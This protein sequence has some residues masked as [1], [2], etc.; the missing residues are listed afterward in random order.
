MSHIALDLDDVILDFTGGV[1]LA[2]K[3]EYGVEVVFNDWDMSKVLNP[4]IGYNWWTWMREREWLW[5]NF[6]AV[7]GAIG[8]IESLRR[9]GHYLEIVTS[10]PDWAEHNVWKW[11]GKWRPRVNKVT[12][13][14]P[15][16]D[17]IRF[18]N[19]S[20]IV[21]DKPETVNQWQDR[22]RRAILFERQHNKL[23]QEAMRP[24]VVVAHNWSEVV[25]MCN[26][27]SGAPV[28]FEVK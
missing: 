25:T 22:G 24:G 6:D 12:I 2:V 16:D 15:K 4:I 27:F 26:S 28:P 17:K 13:T 20:M 5:A 10:K 11:M 1:A 9:R 18:T 7:D 8:G 14:G 23:V 21:D 3:K 19:A